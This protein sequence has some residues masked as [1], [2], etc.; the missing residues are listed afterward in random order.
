MGL[1]LESATGCWAKELWA[2]KKANRAAQEIVR[3]EERMELMRQN[4]VVGGEETAEPGF[5]S[6]FSEPHIGLATKA[7]G[8]LENP[9]PKRKRGT[10]SQ[11]PHLRIGL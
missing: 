5:R 9:N 8:R 3:K 11:V 1:G 2:K 7:S 6:V 4:A 10:I